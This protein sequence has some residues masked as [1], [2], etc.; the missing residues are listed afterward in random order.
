MAGAA[1][2]RQGCVGCPLT[3]SRRAADLGGRRATG[4]ASAVN[5]SSTTKG[6]F[7]VL[8]RGSGPALRAPPST[9]DQR[10]VQAAACPQARAAFKIPKIARAGRVRGVVGEGLAKGGYP[11]SDPADRPGRRGAW[12]R[13]ARP[14]RAACRPACTAGVCAA[15]STVWTPPSVLRLVRRLLAPRPAAGRAAEAE[16]ALP[17]APFCKSPAGTSPPPCVL[18]HFSGH[19]RALLT[20]PRT[21]TQL[22]YCYLTGLRTNNPLRHS[23]VSLHCES[24][25]RP[26]T[27]VHRPF[28]SG[29]ASS[30]QGLPRRG[31]PAGL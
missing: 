13:R 14:P 4:S 23:Q 9:G 16:R 15:H 21:C 27:C 17:T 22:T 8:L 25:L 30:G 5:Y 1:A 10:R 29:G 18:Q 6:D 26:P 2:A 31:C 7:V 20:Q 12:P 28:P 11:R 19:Q 3:L 24:T